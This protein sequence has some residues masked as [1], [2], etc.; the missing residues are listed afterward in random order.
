MGAYAAGATVERR[1]PGRSQDEARAAADAQVQ[2]FLR[3]GWKIAGERWLDDVSGGAPIG[4]AIATGAVSYLAGSGGSLVITY[5]ADGDADLPSDLPVYAGADPRRS[6]L[7]AYAG[8]Q[9]AFGVIAIVVFVI[10]ALF[11]LGQMNRVGDLGAAPPV[12]YHGT[13][14]P[15]Q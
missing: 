15:G 12:L 13:L 11:V 1:Y 4:D 10:F 9:V 7:Q 6:N 5:V 8:L 2:A 14:P 3:S